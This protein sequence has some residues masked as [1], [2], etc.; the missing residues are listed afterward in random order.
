VLSLDAELKAELLAGLKTLQRELEAP[1]ITR[2][3]VKAQVMACRV[4]LMRNGMITQIIKP[5]E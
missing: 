1:Y 5:R 4:A 3:R 2:D